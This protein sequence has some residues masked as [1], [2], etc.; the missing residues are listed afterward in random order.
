MI[1]SIRWVAEMERVREVSLLGTADL[2]YWRDR[3]RSH[4][5]IPAERDGLA[6]VL[7]ISAGMKYWGVQFQELSFSILVARRGEQ[8]RQSGSCL[9]RAFNSRPLFALCERAFFATPYYYGDVRLSQSVPASIRL[10]NA[11]E[12][13]FRAEMRT[14]DS[15]PGGR[16]ALQSGD[17]GWEGPVFLPESRRIRGGQGA[18]FFA[19]IKGQT[20]TYPFLASLDSVTIKP[21]PDFTILQALQESHFAATEWAIR[22][23]ATH[24]KSKT[25][26]RACVFPMDDPYAERG[27]APSTSSQ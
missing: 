10:V 2:A 25:Y 4:D 16:E 27:M 12:D 17:G 1:K 7:V 24:A 23:D 5:L 21:S 22:E 18:L 9:I 11:G 26:Q 3:L 6:Q 20:R 19:R 8:S 14:E 13:V 15:T